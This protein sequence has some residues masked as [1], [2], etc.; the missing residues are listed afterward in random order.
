VV[1]LTEPF[2]LWGLLAGWT[3]TVSKSV[4]DGADAK[5]IRQYRPELAKTSP[6]RAFTNAV[7]TGLVSRSE[8]IQVC[9]RNCFRAVF[10]A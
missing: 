10:A 6:Q 3:A 1:S 8:H 4:S 5:T 7:E 9:R 2:V